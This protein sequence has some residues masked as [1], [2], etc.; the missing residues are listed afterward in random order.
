MNQLVGDLG[1]A[2]ALGGREVWDSIGSDLFRLHLSSSWQPVLIVP[3]DKLTSDNDSLMLARLE[4]EVWFAP[5][6]CML[7]ESGDSTDV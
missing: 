4:L 3:P 6:P 2:L 5:P 7:F 1:G